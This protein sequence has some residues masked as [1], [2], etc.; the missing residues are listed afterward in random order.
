M[1]INNEQKDTLYLFV[2][3]GMNYVIPI[4][5]MPYLMIKLG[6]SS[7]G[8]IGFSTAIIQFL[9]L[10]VD[11]G[12]NMSATKRVAINKDNREVL[13][14]I[15]F[16][17]I[18]AKTILL[19]ISILVFIIILK[20]P[21]FHE[22]QLALLCSLPLLIG[23][24][25]TFTWFFQ[26]IGNIRYL[27]ILSMCCRIL[28]LPTLFYLVQSAQDYVYAIL[29]NSAVYIAISCLSIFWI[30]KNKL[31]V[32]DKVSFQ[33]V[34]LEIKESY[35]FFL[36]TASISIYTQ[37]FVVILGLFANPAVVGIY[38]AA[39]KLIRAVSLLFYT[40]I[41]QVYYPKIA[42]LSSQSKVL[43]LNM[44][45]KVFKFSLYLMLFLS[46]VIFMLSSWIEEIIGGEYVGLANLLIILC[47][48]PVFS[49]I[50]GVAGQMGLI[51]YIDSTKAKRT[52]QNIYI[53][54]GFFAFFQVVIFTYL[55]QEK[56]TSFAVL[57]TEILVAG[58]MC[59][60]FKKYLKIE[61][62]IEKFT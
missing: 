6:V 37:L 54:A 18:Y 13:S 27:S 17:T 1:K 61:S 16:S 9:V 24:A 60:Y 46:L 55:F 33:N 35:P 52:F 43:A 62:N 26:G 41:N 20:L 51:A 59:Y 42:Y 29:V 50:G 15:F 14:N 47:M 8:L 2:L 11:F 38:S 49:A 10:F 57:S 23:S 21:K 28:I 19:G 58:L 53:F 34:K 40:P 7:Y 48:V 3:Q 12:F 45:N 25:F 44:V 32:L 30:Y 39:E 56:G 4:L 36:S 22:Y 31:V 5:L